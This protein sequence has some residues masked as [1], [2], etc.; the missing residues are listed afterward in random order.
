M[1][2]PSSSEALTP[3]TLS[4]FFYDLYNEAPRPLR[5]LIA[6]R[7]YVCPYDKLV[8]FVPE[9]ATVLDFGCG[10]G[11]LLA[12]LAAVDRVGHG[13][14][15]DVSAAPLVAARAAAARIGASDRLDFR[16]IADIDSAPDG[17]FDVVTMV[18]V[19]HHIPP[20]RRADAITAAARRTARGGLFIYKDMTDRPL[21]RRFAH[22][23]DDLVFSHELVRQ[24]RAGE[25]EA[26]AAQSGLAIEHTE[27][28]PR[29][30]Y[31]HEL[32]V[33]RKP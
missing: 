2:V 32:R 21:W 12:V 33:F 18:D 14:G 26:W 15:C 11:S 1:R 25:V 19:L 10:T 28:I 5:M 9:G 27:S 3:K 6:A 7:P 8:S 4:A 13:I 29:L 16:H 22:T 23:V 31:G 24:V 20:P 30:V 17:P